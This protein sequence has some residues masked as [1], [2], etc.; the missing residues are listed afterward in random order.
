[1]E[2]VVYLVS[3]LDPEC[4]RPGPKRAAVEAFQRNIR[5]MLVSYLEGEGRS[6][7]DDFPPE[8]PRDPLWLYKINGAKASPEVKRPLI[9][10]QRAVSK[11]ISAWVRSPAGPGLAG[12]I[13][14]FGLQTALVR[15]PAGGSPAPV[16]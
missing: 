1:M 11:A 6:L 14:T 10:F 2:Q 3:A 4:F 9:E 13:E 12:F 7:M 5:G 8:V 15:A 16:A